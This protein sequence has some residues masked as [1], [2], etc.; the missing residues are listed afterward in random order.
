[1]IDVFRRSL[2][3]ILVGLCCT[4]VEGNRREEYVGLSD[5]TC[6]HLTRVRNEF[7]NYVDK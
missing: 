5:V 2:L 7:I 6:V 4:T 3:T 1:M